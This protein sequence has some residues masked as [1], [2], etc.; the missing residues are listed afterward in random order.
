MARV[1]QVHKLQTSTTF[2]R[3]IMVLINI[4]RIREDILSPGSNF[5][6]HKVI[7]YTVYGH[8]IL[9]FDKPYLSCSLSVFL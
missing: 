8:G 9:A 2:K 4:F 3:D 5:L 1:R 7:D 6:V